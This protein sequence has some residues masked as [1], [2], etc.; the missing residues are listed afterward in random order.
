MIKM[1]KY[2]LID[3]C[4]VNKCDLVLLQQSVY[5]M[6]IEL[7]RGCYK[8]YVYTLRGESNKGSKCTMYISKEALTL[9]LII[10]P[11]HP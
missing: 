2:I 4:K 9:R 5:L 8:N 1:A 7:V 10:F 11:S 6:C 3:I